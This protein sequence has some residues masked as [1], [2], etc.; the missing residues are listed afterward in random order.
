LLSRRVRKGAI[1]ID[2]SVFKKIKSTVGL[3]GYRRVRK[4]DKENVRAYRKDSYGTTFLFVNLEQSSVEGKT[5][6]WSG[7]MA[8]CSEFGLRSYRSV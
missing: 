2:V 6:T 3:H 4:Q 7:L 1:P 8:I 5:Q